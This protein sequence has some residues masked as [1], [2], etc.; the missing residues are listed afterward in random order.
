MWVVGWSAGEG[1][2]MEEIGCAAKTA[3][4]GEEMTWGAWRGRGRLFERVTRG[5]CVQMARIR[6]GAVGQVTVWMVNGV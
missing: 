1:R 6:G 2:G 4:K 3:S 5:V